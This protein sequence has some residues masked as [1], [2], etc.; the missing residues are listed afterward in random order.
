MKKV[1]AL[2]VGLTLVAGVAA[3]AFAQSTWKNC[4]FQDSSLCKVESIGSLN[5]D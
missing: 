4:P 5:N 1:A 3:P 2:L